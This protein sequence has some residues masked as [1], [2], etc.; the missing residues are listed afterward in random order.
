MRISRAL[1]AFGGAVAA[2]IAVAAVISSFSVNATHV[3]G[4]MYDQ[5]V[6]GKDLV[7]DILPPPE[8]VIEAYLE[9]TLAL[10]RAKPLEEAASR[11]KQ[12]H[13][14]YDLRHD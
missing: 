7:A 8:Y 12:L 2:G 4:A 10:N 11:L 9:A 13:A 14:D 1:G 3:G 5:I 6:L